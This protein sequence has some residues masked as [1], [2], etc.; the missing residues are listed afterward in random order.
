MK[1][2]R[3]KRSGRSK[4]DVRVLDM[5]ELEDIIKRAVAGPISDEDAEKLRESL[6]S[7]AWLQQK[8]ADKDITLARLRDLFGLK[9]SEKTSKVLG[10]A[11]S[12]S[13]T[14]DGP[15]NSE[16]NDGDEPGDHDSKPSQ[17]KTRK[18]HGRKGADDYEGAE[19]VKVPHGSLKPGDRCP[20]C[21]SG[22]HGKVYGLPPRTLVRVVGQAPLQATVYELQALRCNLCGTVFVAERP[23]EAGEKKYDA[24]AASMI[25]LLKYGS[26]L[27]FN[28]LERLEGN[29]GIPLP[30]STQYEIVAEAARELRP[31]YRELI[32]QAAQGRLL[33]N[34]DTS[35]RVLALRKEIDK[36]V[37]KGETDRTGIF[38]TTIVSEL[39]DSHRIALFFT[40]RK[41]AGENIT[42][43]L[44]L[45]A[46]ELEKPMQMCDGLDRNLSTEFET[47][48]ANCLAHARRKFVEVVNGFPEE[49]RYILET[50]RDVYAHDR[51]TRRRRLSDDDRLQF[52]QKHSRPLMDD[53]EKWMRRQ[54]E[55][56]L[57]EPNSGLGQAISYMTKRW[58]RLTR[59]L[60]HPGAILDNNIAERALKKAILNRKNALFYKTTAG[61]A[62]G[63]LFMSLI[64]TAE[65]AGANPFDYLT[66]LLQH[67]A[68][69]QRDPSRWMPWSYEA[70]LPHLAFESS[71]KASG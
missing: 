54:I 38:C 24:T 59:F 40:G 31:V 20:E 21:A 45:R 63:D 36:L 69:A 41:H 57:V 44:S 6:G 5:S 53:L 19:R 43:V 39:T 2:R 17:K 42:D 7:L 47:L 66:A 70:A 67:A 14:K 9:T 32:N 25:A 13:Q 52:H 4:P 55:E 16:T 23:K 11:P 64:H 51:T 58:D 37:D 15:S 61:A 30:A 8:L 48:V 71:R 46:A 35:M 26:G 10:K 22:K 50:L 49:C 28:R 29:L 65:L 60:A 3:K 18:G 34:D 27:P 33:Y 62:V 56:K 68:T 1:G 12:N